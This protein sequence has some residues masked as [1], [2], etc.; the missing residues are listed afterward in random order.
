AEVVAVI[1]ANEEAL[2]AEVTLAEVVT[3][4]VLDQEIVLEEDHSRNVIVP[5][6]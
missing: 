1:E 3:E 5:F 6:I 2:V 4:I